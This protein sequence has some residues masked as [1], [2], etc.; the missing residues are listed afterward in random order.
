ME[1]NFKHCYCLNLQFG[2]QKIFLNTFLG[3]VPSISWSGLYRVKSALLLWVSLLLY[4][5]IILL[6]RA[7]FFIT[8]DFVFRSS[9][10]RRYC[11]VSCIWWY[12]S[13]KKKSKRSS[14]NDN[15]LFSSQSIEKFLDFRNLRLIHYLFKGAKNLQ[16]L[17]IK[18][19]KK[20]Y[21]T[22]LG[23]YSCKVTVINA[24]GYQ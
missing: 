22:S 20:F 12:T 7:F 11:L 9:V 4:S 17:S 15:R 5:W 19:A 13:K 16:L 6:P 23:H 3:I 8:G 18:F 21:C 24:S 2:G 14:D 10:K 1:N